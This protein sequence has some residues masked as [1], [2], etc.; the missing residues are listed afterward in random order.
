MDKQTTDSKPAIDHALI[1]SVFVV[2]SCG[3]AYELVNAALA[4]YLL[5]DS[6]LQFSTII[7]AYLFAMGIG[8]H[9]SQYVPED[10][11]LKRFIEIELLVGLIGGLSATALFLSFAWIAAPFRPLL[12]AMVILIGI[13]VGMEVP[14][15]MRVLNQRKAEFNALI[16]RVLTFDYM[17]ALAVSLL[18]PLVL[19]PMLGLARTAILFG[20]CNVGIACWT[21]WRFRHDLQDSYR[22][23]L[24]RT[25]A[26]L[27]ILFAGFALA[28]RLVSWSENQLFGDPIV[29]AKT[30]PYQ[31]LVLTRWHDDLRLYIN[32]NLQFSSTDEYRYHEALVHPVLH[33]L[34]P[35]GRVLI[36][37]GGDGL[38]LR[39]VLRDQRVK[40]VTLVDLDP[41]MTEIFS[42]NP[43]LVKL[44]QNALAD[45]RVTVVNQDAAQW[46]EQHRGLYDV[47]IVDFPDPSNFGLGKLYSTPIYRLMKQHLQ[48]DGR[49]VVQSTS[50]LYAPRAFWS[51]VATLEK[52]GF[53][54]TPYH[55][56]V[57]SF[58][59]WGFVIASQQN[60]FKIPS[61]YQLPMRFLDAMTTAQMFYFPKDMQRVTVEPNDLNSQKLVQYFIQDWSGAAR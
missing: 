2:A 60:D 51:I 16:S 17:G 9:L 38:A 39:E 43:D 55:A 30:T 3:L 1:I 37:G 48:P 15:V 58:G 56:L 26:V 49:M 22:Q 11:V 28:D 21:V 52:A 40:D 25:V 46:L 8:S 18:F 23:L 59:E 53:Y 12:Y 61:D 31:R 10:Q 57:P 42:T 24:R 34:H 20:L 41:A 33:D 19:A 4:S 29:Y 14:L 32:G 45:P 47:M 5:G 7:G 35:S 54:T 36:L 50:P 6:V 13:L 44:N 27:I